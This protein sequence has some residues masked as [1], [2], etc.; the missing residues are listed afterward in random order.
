M[1]RRVLIDAAVGLAG[2]AVVMAALVALG[3]WV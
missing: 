1:V 3:A 2:G